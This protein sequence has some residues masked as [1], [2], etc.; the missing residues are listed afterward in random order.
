MSEED[1]WTNDREWTI[2]GILILVQIHLE[3]ESSLKVT[4]TLLIS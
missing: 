3:A 2:Y 4:E 1:L